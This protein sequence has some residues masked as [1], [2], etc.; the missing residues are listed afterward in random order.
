M[1]GPRPQGTHQFVLDTVDPLRDTQYCTCGLPA[2][3]ERHRLPER[4]EHER[5]TEARRLGEAPP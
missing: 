3:N 1:T 4:D 5:R 2:S